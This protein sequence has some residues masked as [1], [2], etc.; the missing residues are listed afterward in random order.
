[1]WA[2]RC[3]QLLVAAQYTVV[4]NGDVCWR[5]GVNTCNFQN[6]KCNT[7][8]CALGVI[9]HKCIA[10]IDP[11]GTGGMRCT[12]NAVVESNATHLERLKDIFVHLVT[13]LHG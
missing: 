7:T 10:G 6:G 8:L 1:M 5:A 9:R 13:P 12:H 4:I 2:N 3:H 11:A